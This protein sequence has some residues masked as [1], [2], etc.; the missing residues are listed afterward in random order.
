MEPKSLTVRYT[1]TAQDYLRG[2]RIHMRAKPYFYACVLGFLV[3]IGFVRWDRWTH[4][5]YIR[6]N[7]IILCYAGFWILYIVAHYFWL[8]PRKIEKIYRQSK[9]L[10]EE[11]TSVFTED[12][13]EWTF[14]HGRSMFE[15]QLFCDSRHDA[16][17]ILLYHARRQFRMV[18]RRAFSSDEDFQWL[19]DLIRRKVRKRS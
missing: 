13:T 19:L 4:D 12:G 14:R 5:F 15:W 11:M 1:I 10:H 8:L 9:V 2:A 3:L 16:T 18:P 17:L 7:T 6:P